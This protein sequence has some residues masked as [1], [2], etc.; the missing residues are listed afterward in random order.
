MIDNGSGALKVGF[1]G[2]SGPR[3]T[4]PSVI[5]IP[6]Q[7]MIVNKMNLRSPTYIGDDA[8]NQR[9]ILDLRYPVQNGVI[10]DWDDMETLWHH[11]FHNELRISPGIYPLLLTETPLN[12]NSNREKMAE[13]MFEKF[14]VPSLYFALQSV[15]AVYGAGRTT[16]TVLVS[17]LMRI[18]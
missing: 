13:I 18:N 14:R 15:L 12:P 6:Q 8:H 17:F 9:G 10:V 4:F 5:G 1:A 11:A 7:P 16:A 3:A 2:E